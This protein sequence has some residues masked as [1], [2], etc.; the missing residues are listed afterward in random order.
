MVPPVV[1]VVLVAVVL[2][3]ALSCAARETCADGD[4]PAPVPVVE[5]QAGF[6]PYGHAHN[7]FDNDAPLQSALDVGLYS[8]E[9]DL[10]LRGDEIVVKHLPWDTVV[11]TLAELYLDPLQA[12][13][14]DRGSVHGDGVPF[15]LW[16]DLK[17]G[18]TKM[19]D[20][21]DALLR[22]Y[23]MLTTYAENG[24]QDGRVDV[25]L[26]GDA[27]AKERMTTTPTPRPYA[28][29]AN[30]FAVDDPPADAAWRA[31]ALKWPDYVPWGGAGEPPAAASRAV[32][33]LVDAAHRDGRKVRFFDAPDVEASWRFQLD[34]GVDFVGT[35]DIA[36]LAAL[37]STYTP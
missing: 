18:S 14:D 10:H 37:L 8:V 20:A 15:T 7:D 22:T 17:D 29:D 27:A 33:C 3:C 2:A 24:V 5:T 19:T 34:H 36:G 16:L 28:R 31:Y 25:L 6:L 13:V 30:A 23:P 32:A 11:G 9:A 26:T 1:R 21:L 35:D 4:E 12:I